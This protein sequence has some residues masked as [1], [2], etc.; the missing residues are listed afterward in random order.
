MTSMALLMVVSRFVFAN[1]LNM[2]QFLSLSFEGAAK[3]FFLGIMF[4]L[5]LVVAIFNLSRHLIK[6]QMNKIII[7]PN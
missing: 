5:V 1:N 3:W 4:Y 6:T 2:I 7:K